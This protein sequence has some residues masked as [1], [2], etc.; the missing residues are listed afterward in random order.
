MGFQVSPGVNVT[1]IDLTTIVPAVSTTEAAFAG[2]FR[3]GPVELANL[4]SSEEELVNTYGKPD[5]TNFETFFT[6]A[7][8]LAYGNKLYVSRAT[9][10]TA[11]NA[12]VLQNAATSEDSSNTSHTIRIKNEEH[13]DNDV[14]VPADASFLARYPGSLGNSLK[15]S[16]CDS[17]GAFESTVSNT[18]T[19]GD[20][21]KI[22]ISVGNTELV[23]TAQD[24]KAS[25]T[26]TSN[27]TVAQYLLAQNT[28]ANIASSFAVGDVI[29]LGNSSIGFTE[30]RVAAIGSTTTSGAL[31]NSDADTQF[32][33]T[34]NITLETKYAL[35]TDFT[36]NLQA[37]S[38]TR[39]WQFAEN[40]EKAPGT[41]LWC[42][43]VANTTDASDELHIVVQDEDGAI[44]G[45]RGT[46]LESYSN[47]SR[48]TDAKNESGES[49][50]YYD[51]LQNQSR[52]V[53]NGGKKVRP[54]SET[55]NSTAGYSNT[56]VNMSN[57]A[58]TNT[59]PFS[60]SFTLGRD[61]GSANVTAHS[62][63]G[64]SD[65]GE[66]N[67][68]I[69]QLTTAYDKF[70]NAEEIDISIVLQ[71]KARGGTHGHQLGNYLID[72]IAEPRKDCVVVISPE[73]A[74]V[75]NNFGNESAN[76]VD[77]RNA[78][79]SSSYGIM[80]GGYKY[81]YDRY[82]DVYRYVPYNGDIA[83]LMVRSDN[84]RDPWYSPAGF[85]RGILKNV[86]KNSYNPDKADRDILYKNGVNPIV[87]FPGQGTI[88]FGDK[89]L[90]ARPSAFD[91][92]NV[93]R[94]FIVLEKAIST[95]A[96]FTLFEFNDEFTRA[97]FRNLV[98]P[99]LRDVQGRRGIFD[100]KVVCDET[101]N[102]G[103]VIDR[104]EF[105]G[106]IYIKPAR[107]INF[108]QLNFIAVRTNVE[109]SEV[110]GQF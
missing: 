8:F 62:L 12:T 87:T 110:V 71:G 59:V 20:T 35:S 50:Y 16:V 86:I 25:F 69:G 96:K 93:R 17:S 11:L 3:W 109:F 31:V 46:I 108:I 101:N 33:A 78:L 19:G 34:A 38:V 52:W 103:E 27:V 29:R 63:T 49:I 55:Q 85:N 64:D 106:D 15:I 95:A 68:A 1:E 66:A 70:K 76:T 57:S 73:K 88:M 48:A 40:F 75:I 98:E 51:V 43:N 36:A 6:A 23:I 32:T 92:I 41:S 28:A 81:Q 79:T 58:V 105:I 102:T 107:S 22:E 99:F 47:L 91:R 53:L 77:F 37:T 72:N 13:Y 26:Q 21:A 84:L 100:F 42:N 39:K 24:T 83:G 14:T 44:S 60:R 61:G 74:D 89:T 80:D 10:T 90:L 45:V 94:L 30:K 65:S 104:N 18:M 82:N 5:G 67:I 7:N 9:A 56:G 2:H 97:Q 4:V 54:D